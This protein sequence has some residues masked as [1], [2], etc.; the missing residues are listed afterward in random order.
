L[1]HNDGLPKHLR[2]APKKKKDARGAHLVALDGT[3]K[4]RWIESI[5]EI[6]SMGNDE[7]TEIYLRVMWKRPLFTDNPERF[8]P[9]NPVA[10]D[11]Y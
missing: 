9:L 10:D 3:G 2:A 11:D 7:N 8:Y 4:H 5:E 1:I 6:K